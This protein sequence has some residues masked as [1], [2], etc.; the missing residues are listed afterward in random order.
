MTDTVSR[1]PVRL[2]DQDDSLD[3][4]RFAYISDRTYTSDEVESMTQKVAETTPE[5]VKDAPNAKMFLRSLWYRAIM[6]TLLSSD[7]MHVYT[8]ARYGHCCNLCWLFCIEH[9]YH[10]RQKTHTMC[11]AVQLLLAA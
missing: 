4:Q 10:C 2:T 9:H 1:T 8:V 5:H 11:A 7:E 6:S 3:A